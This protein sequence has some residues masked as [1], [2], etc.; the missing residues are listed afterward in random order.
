M[1]GLSFHTN[2]SFY[3]LTL[4]DQFISN[5]YATYEPVWADTEDKITGLKKYGEDVR[6]GNQNVGNASYRRRIGFYGLL[7]YD[8]TF[9]DV[10]HFSGSLLAYLTN[11][12]MQTDLQGVKNANLGLRLAYGFK[13]KYLVDFSS[14][15]VNSVKL[16]EGN[17]TAFSPSLGLAWMISSESFMSSVSAIDYLKLRLSAGSLNSDNGISGFYNYDERYTGSGS[18][19]WYEGT[20]SR[21]GVIPSNG[22]NSSLAFEK[23]KE[24]NLGLES[25]LFKNRLSV[26]ANV[27]TSLYSDQITRPQTIY[28]SYFS[29][30][31]P[32]RNFEE[33]SYRGAELGLSYREQVGDFTIVAGVNVLYATSKVKKRDE[34]FAQGYRNRTN[35]PVDATF[36]LVSEGLFSDKEDIAGHELQAFGNVKPG[37]IKYVDQNGDGIIDANDERRIGRSQAPLSYG[38]NLRVSYK[39]LTL[40]ARGNGRVGADAML[41]NNYFWVDGDDKYS[42]YILGRWTEATKATATLPRLSSIANTNNYRSSD[43]W[44]FRDNYFTVDRLQ[45]TYDF[46]VGILSKLNVRA[47][48]MFV[49]ASNLV[50]LSKNRHIKELTIGAEP[51]YRS[52]SLG[53]NISF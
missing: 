22:G 14:A 42:T 17:R 51:Q 3:Y 35:Q 6:T 29:T 45:L 38:L 52:Y 10:H 37:D 46:P 24:I 26:N 36:G 9:K 2:M 8:R 12:K 18:Y 41:S 33:N 43:F 20:R 48:S 16:P 7:D 19:A 4:Y 23:R 30:Y 25:M 44:L 39:K 32:Y 21:T 40:F 28:P 47:F 31:I 1:Q 27:F 13:N 50:M 53:L 49:D 34:L 5:T 11:D 15:Y